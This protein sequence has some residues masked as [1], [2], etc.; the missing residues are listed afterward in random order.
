MAGGLLSHYEADDDAIQWPEIMHNKT[1][2]LPL[3]FHLIGLFSMAKLPLE[4]IGNEICFIDWTLTLMPNQQCQSN[5]GNYINCSILRE[6][7]TVIPHNCRVICHI[8]LQF[9]VHYFTAVGFA[10]VSAFGLLTAGCW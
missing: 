2:T 1:A 10:P 4:T 8:T 3:G 6:V 7:L 9:P 5:N